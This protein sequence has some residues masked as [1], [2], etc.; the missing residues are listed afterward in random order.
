MDPRLFFFA[1]RQSGMLYVLYEKLSSGF[2][3]IDFIAL[4]E[5]IF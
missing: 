2:P 5:A 4:E 1:C 3:K